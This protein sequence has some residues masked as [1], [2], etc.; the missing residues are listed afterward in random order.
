MGYV[1]GRG[2]GKEEQGRSEPL[3][4]TRVLPAGLAL[5]YI[6]E[7]SSAP[8]DGGKRRRRKKSKQLPSSDTTRTIFDFM[9][10]SFAESGS[11]QNSSRTELL[12]DIIDVPR[13]PLST[14]GR[15]HISVNAAH[16]NSI[17]S[18]NDEEKRLEAKLVSFYYSLT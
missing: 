6:K 10:H 18:L 8:E 9:N 7:V 2:L 15:P 3:P 16:G 5:D 17:V 13:L 4:V 1:V 11:G 12:K 14:T